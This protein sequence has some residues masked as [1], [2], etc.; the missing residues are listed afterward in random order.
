MTYCTHAQNPQF[1]SST[2]KKKD[3]EKTK[4]YFEKMFRRKKKKTS[5]QDDPRPLCNFT[6][7]IRNATNLPNTDAS[8][9]SASAKNVADPY[10]TFFLYFESLDVVS[11]IHSP[12]F[13]S[14]SS[15][16]HHKQSYRSVGGRKKKGSV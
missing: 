4:R 1:R 15:H 3:F 13:C 7:V 6:F 16:H 14:N 12:V 5:F 8:D 10:C 9:L 11:T 2:E